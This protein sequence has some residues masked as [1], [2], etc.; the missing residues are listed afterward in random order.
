MARNVAMCT[1]PRDLQPTGKSWTSLSST[2]SR[3]YVRGIRAIRCFTSSIQRQPL[4]APGNLL[5]ALHFMRTLVQVLISVCKTK[6]K[7][8]E[9]Q[10]WFLLLLLL[11]LLN[12][13]QS[14]EPGSIDVELSFLKIL[15]ASEKFLNHFKKSMFPQ[16]FK[17]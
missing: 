11:N 3:T 7:T 6:K 12:I 13:F 16:M 10:K 15:N 14:A 8:F 9:K 4:L 17:R 2:K 5:L 1:Y